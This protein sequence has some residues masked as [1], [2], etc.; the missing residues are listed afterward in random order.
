[1]ICI[2][3]VNSITKLCE[4]SSFQKK[5]YTELQQPHTPARKSE[6]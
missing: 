6:Q 3:I 1:V 2:F 5:M 4:I